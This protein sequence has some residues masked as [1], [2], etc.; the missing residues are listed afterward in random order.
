MT[1]LDKIFYSPSV[2]R[3]IQFFCEQHIANPGKDFSRIEIQRGA[4]VTL[5]TLIKILPDLKH[6]HILK[7]TR[8]IG[9]GHCEMYALN[10]A[11]QFTPHLIKLAESL[12]E[13]YAKTGDRKPEQPS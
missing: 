13:L 12:D 8:K 7:M 3:V 1:G 9:E 10:T 5:R 6:F 4:G 11:Q 2:V